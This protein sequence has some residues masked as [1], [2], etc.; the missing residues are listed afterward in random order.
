TDEETEPDQSTGE[1]PDSSLDYKNDGYIE[2]VLKVMARMCD[3]QNQ[4]LQNYLREQPDNVKSFDIIAEVTRFLDVVYSNINGRSIDLVIQLFDSINEFTASNQDNRVVIYDNKI[5]DYI[6]FI[7]RA[8]DFADCPTEKVLELRQSI[9][10]LIVSL[11][12]ENGPGPSQ[13][14]RE[15]KDTLDKKAVLQLMT[16]CYEMHQPDKTKL[17]DL[18]NLSGSGSYMQTAKSFALAGGSFIQGV[19]PKAKDPL[20]DTYMDVG[21]SLYIILARMIDIDPRVFLTVHITPQQQKAFNFYKKNC[22]SIEI[23]KDDCLQKI[24]FRVRNKR[25]LRE[26]VKEKLKWNVDR[27]SP[28]NKIRDLMEW[29]KDI[30]KDIAYQRRIL[31]NPLA[32]LLTKGWLFWNHMVTILSFAI[33]IMMLITWNAKASLQKGNST[34]IEGIDDPVPVIHTLT[35]EQYTI[36]IYVMG[37]M[38]NFF[39]MLV[40]ISYF[41]CNHPSLPNLKNIVIFFKKLTVKKK[42]QEEDG[43]NKKKH[44]SKLECKFFSFVTFFYL[45]FV[46]LSIGGTVSHGYF[47]AFHL[48]NIVNN[49]QLLGGVIKAVTQNGKSLVWVGILGMVVF[50]LY[51]I[52]GFAMMRNMFD[53]NEYLYC[54]SL[55]Q[56]TVTVVRYGLIGDLFESIKAHKDE[57][58]FAKFGLVVLFHVSFFIFITTIGLNIIFGIIVDTFSELRDLKWTAE[59]D[60]RDT[61]FI[62]S[63][64]SY[65]FEHHGKGFEHHVMYEHNMW[66]YIFF[67][68]HLNGTKVND[69]NAL[70]MYVFRLLNKE[71]YDFFPLDRALSLA[72]MGKDATE[73]KL[74]DLLD[75]VTS[76]VE[77]QR[78]EETEKKRREERMRQKLWEQKHRLG[79]FRRKAKLPVPRE[80]DPLMQM[81]GGQFGAMED[82][83]Y[84]TMRQFSDTHNTGMSQPNNGGNTY[85]RPEKSGS[86][87]TS[88]ISQ[89]TQ[90]TSL[91][92]YQEADTP[93]HYRGFSPLRYDADEPG[94]RNLSPVCYD[95]RTHSPSRSRHGSDSELLGFSP[96]HMRR[97]SRDSSYIRQVSPK[98]ADSQAASPKTSSV[99]F[100]D[101]DSTPSLNMRDQRPPERAMPTVDLVTDPLEEFSSFVISEDIASR[102]SDGEDNDDDFK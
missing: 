47:F 2:L 24:N 53:P 51:G 82:P 93:R 9:A 65:D 74:D 71:N 41:V 91:R 86:I 59:S 85:S 80:Y 43:D 58:T 64:N 20:A 90:I 22:S 89:G 33:N 28:S 96:I 45:M 38:H 18:K 10:N 29:A 46:T 81:Q 16:E 102:E 92:E 79:S 77:K 72:S 76:I 69:Y 48:L 84:M 32:L 3:G 83:R 21:F 5:I 61:C 11:V 35:Q 30:M 87:Y 50:Y 4:Q 88:S 8:G 40:L 73:T 13:V 14:A 94:V 54:A 62:C 27:S 39:S 36:A 1:Q 68:I 19:I 26:E 6:N 12:E 15:V 34:L 67:F 101:S 37:G 57:A 99:F 25:V 78:R 98:W 100:P 56:C 70:E 55:W 17:E 49:N 75:Q 66:A 60:M 95:D 97:Q 42:K 52:I 63:R 23:V 31:G 7:L 44:I